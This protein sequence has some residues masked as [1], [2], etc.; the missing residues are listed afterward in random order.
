MRVL[1]ISANR[2][3]I[4]MRTWPLGL[5][6]VAAATRKA[7]HDVELLDLML[8]ANPRSELARSIESFGPDV[9]GI[10]VRNIDDQTMRDTKFFL[11]Q[12]RAFIADCRDLTGAP[13]VLGGAGYSIFPQSSLE[14]LAADMGIQGEGEAAFLALLDRLAHN[15]SLEGVPGLYLPGVGLQGARKFEKNLAEL[16]LPDTRFLSASLLDDPEFWFPVQT[17][18]GC[19]MR[20][21]Y[22]S[23]AT[24]E[25]CAFRKRSPA[26][27]TRWLTA[28]AQLGVKRVYFVDNTF[29]L[30][31]SY[32]RELC[33]ELEAA[34]LGIT[35]RCIL[36]PG[37]FDEKLAKAMAA[38]GCTEV[39]VGFES[40][41]Q[42]ILH[43]LNKKFSPEGVRETCRVLGNQGIRR[44]GFLMLGGPGETRET[45]LESLAFAD[46]LGLE[47]MKVTVGIRIYPYTA[48]AATA[49][50]HGM[51]EDDD[52]LLL[53][54]FYVTPG[55]GEWL[56]E[57]ADRWMAERPNW[58]S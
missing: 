3:E 24:I 27:V 40:G 36:Y 2:E 14:Y 9:I 1:L 49:V 13:I 56:R 47:T 30:P 55:L 33:S 41:A 45:A 37:K 52:D 18:R 6:C 26:T 44:M 23:T 28:W 8:A 21:S 22:C 50:D 17:R 16:P 31:P 46:S 57:T 38:A 48:L 53:P 51:I 7:G 25:G 32:A 20:C 5:A 39:S 10:S 15:A 11:D 58:I 42:P 54:R 19:P 4:N 34:R 29:N 12:V 35:W 43:G